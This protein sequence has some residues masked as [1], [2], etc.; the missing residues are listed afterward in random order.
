MTSPNCEYSFWLETDGNL[1][2]Y[3]GLTNGRTNLWASQTAGR[4][5]APYKLKMQAHDQH[6]VL[7][8]GNGDAIWSTGVYGG[9]WVDGAYLSIQDDG[10]LVVYD[11]T[12]E[13]GDAMWSTGTAEGKTS[14]E[15]GTGIKHEKSKLFRY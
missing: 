6:L 4:G 9:M 12:V 2:L 5:T 1:K 10:N 8:D 7:Y 3:K 15:Y 13:K 11:G 14:T